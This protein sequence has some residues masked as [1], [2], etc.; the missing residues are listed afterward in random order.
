MD[1]YPNQT[2]VD[3][4]INV[5]PSIVLSCKINADGIIEYVN[6]SFSEV[7]GYEEFEIIGESMDILHHPDV[8]KVIYDILKE[9]LSKNESVKLINKQLAKDGRYYWLLSEYETKLNEAGKLV[10]HY[11]H[12]VTAPPFAVHKISSLYKILTK[13]ESKS[14]N[15]DVS[16]RYLIGFL[17]ERN[18]NYNQFIDELCANQPE[19]E[20]T[21]QQQP[22]NLEQPVTEIFPT[23]NKVQKENSG[24]HLNNLSYNANFDISNQDRIDTA[25]KHRPKVKKKKSLLKKVFG[26]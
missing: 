16:K 9:R 17:E 23:K 14:N 26:K 24:L 5:N 4:E 12:S 11:S 6:H 22:A 2:P 7:S 20:K 18:L 21:F 8:P 19:F 3:R 15:T 1:N 13:I 10:A 25:A